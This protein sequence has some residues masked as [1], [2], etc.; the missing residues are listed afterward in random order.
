MSRTILA[1]SPNPLPAELAARCVMFSTELGWMALAWRNDTVLRLSFGFANPRAARESI[2]SPIDHC[3]LDKLPRPIA[4]IVK[5]LTRFAAGSP[6]DF[7]DVPLDLTHLT[8]FQLRV[9]HDCRAIPAGETKAYAELAKLAGSPRAARAVGNV[10][11]SNRHPL[12]V[13]C[14]RVIGSNG[15]LRGFTSPQGLSMKER[16]LARECGPERSH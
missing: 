13:P 4:K 16:L 7:Q 10:M 2:T 8:P 6:D 3:E 11:R 12:I 5:R 1:R 14:H 9:I 15:A